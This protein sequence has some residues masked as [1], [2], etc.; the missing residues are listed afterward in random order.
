MAAK[1]SLAKL[2][3]QVENG[4]LSAERAKR[5]FL[6]DKTSRAAF[7]PALRFNPR[8]VD[9][10]GLESSAEAVATALARDIDLADARARAAERPRSFALKAYG[11]SDAVAAADLGATILAEGDSW[12][13]LPPFIYPRTLIDFLGRT[14]RVVTLAKW[15]DTLERMIAKKEF[16]RPLRTGAFKH[17]LFSGGGNDI[18]GGGH[19]EVFLRQF[20]I[21]HT[22]PSDA[23]WYVNDQF[24][25]ALD[26]VMGL[27]R[28]LLRIVRREAPSTKLLVHGYAYAIPQRDGSWLGEGM[29][30]RG[31]H[32][33]YRPELCRAI[34]KVMI[35]AFNARLAL[36][37]QQSNGD[38]VHVNLRQ[39]A[40]PDEW[41]DELHA[42]E[43]ATQR[44]AQA[45]DNALG[46]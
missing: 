8:T 12:F 28:E 42:R 24:V 36:F 32:P 7:S 5:Y 4:E 3:A 44:F 25:L 11:A 16:V 21:A 9:I 22:N 38:V 27:Y 43:I 14:H 15:G 26:K 2:M 37:A 10:T 23:A 1:L 29:Q 30:F 35:D 46:P 20:D 31:L 18:V 34:I 17:F 13:D 19:L 33:A 39:L 41:F 6:I 45:F 40:S